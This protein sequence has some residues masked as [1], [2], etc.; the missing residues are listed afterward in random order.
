MK[1]IILALSLLCIA[2][3]FGQQD[4]LKIITLNAANLEDALHQI[5]QQTQQTFFYQKNGLKI[6][7]NP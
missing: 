1:K 2:P 3:L 7:R 5:E 4:T 6:I